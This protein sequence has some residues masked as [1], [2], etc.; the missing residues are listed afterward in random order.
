MFD[1]GLT[2]I[3]PVDTI[4]VMAT[5][6]AAFGTLYRYGFRPLSRTVRIVTKLFRDLYG[7]DIDDVVEG[8][9]RQ[10]GVFDR[11]E[12]TQRRIERVEWEVRTNGEADSLRNIALRAE[13]AAVDTNDRLEEH[14][15]WSSQVV[16]EQADH[17]AEL[18][19]R[20]EALEAQRGY[21]DPEPPAQEGT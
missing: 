3:G 11:I 5:V 19:A 8:S 17:L 12:A 21:P 10:Q 15:A 6:A 9:Q 2:G 18:R 4:L 7:Q 14:L 16:L 1:G 20:L 13:K